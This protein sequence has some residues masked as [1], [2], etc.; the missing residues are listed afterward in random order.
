MTR[1]LGTFDWLLQRVNKGVLALLLCTILV[2]VVGY[3]FHP[4]VLML[5]PLLLLLFVI[6]IAGPWLTVLGLRSELQFDKERVHEQEE[7]S[8]TL[9]Y[10]QKL[11]LPPWGVVAEFGLGDPRWLPSSL[12]YRAEEL[13]LRLVPPHRGT[14][15]ARVPEQ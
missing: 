5:L 13:K 8:A 3:A 15:P 7:V 11:P 2:A 6:G 10:S 1:V 14:F 4:R 12:P 9:R